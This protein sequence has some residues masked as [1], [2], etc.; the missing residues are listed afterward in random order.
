MSQEHPSSNSNAEHCMEPNHPPQTEE[1]TTS[2]LTPNCFW[3][4]MTD[5]GFS[6]SVANPTPS[7]VTAKAFLGLTNQVQ[8]L[9]G[10]VQTIVHQ[11]LD[12]VQKE[13]LKSKEEFGGE[14]Q[15]WLPAYARTMVGKRPTHE[16]NLDITFWSGNEEYSNHDDALVISTRMANA[17]VKRVMINMGSSADILYLDAFQKLGLTDKDLVSLTSALTGFTGDSV[18]PLGAT[19]IP[20]TFREEPKSKT[21]MVSFMVVGLPSTYNTI[22]GRPTLN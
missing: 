15:R 16:D 22:I 21:L 1:V 3:R 7:V 13:V 9:A 17:H 19:T 18:S 5:P 20:V 4:M 11:R 12:E 14:L 6:P 8:A 2:V 10:M